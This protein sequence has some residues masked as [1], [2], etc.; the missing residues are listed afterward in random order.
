MSDEGFTAEEIAKADAL[1]DLKAAHEQ[2]VT[3]LVA[4]NAAGV[5]P[6]E[7]LASVGIEIPPMLAP[8]LSAAID[9]LTADLAKDPA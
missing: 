7:S 1:G 2:F 4:C 9:G 3:A 6:D 5:S 8:M